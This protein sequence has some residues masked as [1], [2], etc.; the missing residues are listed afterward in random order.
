LRSLGSEALWSLFGGKY[1]LTISVTYHSFVYWICKLKSGVC[2][3]LRMSL[4]Q[5]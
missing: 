2:K 4:T 3:Y 5:A 1:V